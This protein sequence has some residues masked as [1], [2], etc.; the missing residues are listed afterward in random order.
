MLLAIS[1]ESFRAAEDGKGER[2]MQ[3][4]F[5]AI[6]VA[7]TIAVGLAAAVSRAAFS[8]P[9]A[10]DLRIGIGAVTSEPSQSQPPPIA[11]GQT[12]TVT[13]LHFYVYVLLFPDSSNPATV[14]TKVHIVLSDGL[15]W[16]ADAPDPVDET[17]TSTPTTGDCQLSLRPG[18]TGD[19]YYWN[20]TAAQP[21]TYTYQATIIESSEADPNTS[22]NTSSLTIRVTDEPSGGGGGG[23]AVGV[24]SASA[25]KLAPRRPVA[26]KAVSA[27]VQVKADGAAVKPTSV[28]CSGSTGGT[29]VKGTPRAA[30]GRAICVYRTPRK[31]KGKV[32]RGAVSL[33]VGGQRISKTF[34]ARLG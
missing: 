34:S 32:F 23:G 16:G 29:A 27:V 33:S 20:V 4:L 2:L 15:Q 30:L 21:G 12:V 10:A 7:T 19:G 28:R 17:C 3:R 26:G 13:S 11:S 5:I 31:A 22:N 24:V 14:Q 6:A 9:Q 25:A 18:Q 1:A 8:A